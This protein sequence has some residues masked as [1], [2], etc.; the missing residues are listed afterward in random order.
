MQALDQGVLARWRFRAPADDAI[1]GRPLVERVLASRG[2]VEREAVER[3]TNPT[4]HLLHDASLLPGVEQAAARLLAS[5]SRGGPVVIYG[6]YDVDGITA[7]AILA[8]TCRAIAPQA[9]MRT[10]IPHR[11]EEG[12][13]LNV[14]AIEQI[15]AEKAD[16]IL[17]VDCGIT[18]R[19]EAQR[20]RQLG[21]DLIITDHHELPVDAAGLPEATVL[22]HPRLPGSAYP[23]GDLCGAGVAFKLAWRLAT[24]W[25][26][27]E[28]VTDQLRGVLKDHLALAALG[29]IADVVPLV[30]ENRIIA[31]YGLRH[32]RDTGNVGLNALITAVGLDDADRIDGE[33]VGFRLAPRLNAA[34]RM[35]HA[36]EALRLFTTDDPA[37]AQQ[38]AAQL[39]RQNRQRQNTEHAI[40]QQAREMAEQAGMT[41]DERRIIV[42]AHEQWHAGVVGIVCSRLAGMFHRPAVLAQRAGDLIKGSA[43]SI[44]GYS[45]CGALAAVGHR[46]LTHGGHDMAGGFSMQAGAWEAFVEELTAHANA[47]VQPADMVRR[48]EIDAPAGLAEIDQKATRALGDLGPFG[49]GNPPPH[50]L[51]SDLRLTGEARVMGEQG[52]HLAL[53]VSSGRSVMRLVGWNLGRHAPQFASGLR[54]D[55]VIRPKLNSWNGRVS[56]EGE[57]TDW[58]KS[59]LA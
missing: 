52:K 4:L 34:G 43:R 29:T 25:C 14:E 45:I 53:Q 13:G 54:I 12:Y 16:L 28:R 9:D 15:A 26:A 6:D 48:L 57:L 7:A 8:H 21:V 37:E 56:V 55:A 33:A 19:S 32:M 51:V 50:L 31:R 59:P 42:L 44:E 49:R 39:E 1:A 38:L 40:V 30:D 41:G 20:A 58:R 11:L 17:T 2:V 18:A 46:L 36:R 22:V 5:L 24:M 3:F 35:G 10:Y 47:H 27:S 23:F